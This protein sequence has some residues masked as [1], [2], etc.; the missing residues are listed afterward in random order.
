MHYI[1][2]FADSFIAPQQQ[3]SIVEYVF[4]EENKHVLLFLLPNEVN[5]DCIR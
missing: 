1:R 5:C 4:K 3:M 2:S